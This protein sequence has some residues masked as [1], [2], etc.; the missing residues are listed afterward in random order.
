M[1][2]A[3]GTISI[4]RF[5]V[6]GLVPKGEEVID[7]L[8]KKPFRPFQDGVEEERSGV[9][10]AL[11]HLKGGPSKD[12]AYTFMDG[13]VLFGLRIDTRKV[14][15]AELNAHLE[16]RLER[17]AKE[18]DL[19]F[20]GKEARTSLRD[21]VKAELLGKV[22]PITKVTESIWN[23]RGGSL[24]IAGGNKPITMGRALLTELFGAETR[25][26]TPV[27]LASML[28]PTSTEASLLHG[29]A[30]ELLEPLMGQLFLTW[31]WKRAQEDGGT[32]NE[33]DAATLLFGDSLK[34]V[35]DNGTIKEASLKKGEPT[36]SHAALEA[37][38]EGMLPAAAKV[39][40]LSGELEW[41]FTLDHNLRISGLKLP[42]TAGN[43]Q[44]SRLADRI[45]LVEELLGHIDLRF[46]EFLG[47]WEA[48]PDRLQEEAKAW[49]RQHVNAE[50]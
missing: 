21:E 47:T 48:G 11:N 34:L 24:L 14:P 30:R 41:T 4:T 28:L 44:V 1:G 35:T 26:L 18:K 31:L 43:D 16:L 19:A 40:V 22:R 10:D 7:D 15:A 42:K 39:R 5:Q 45:F 20:I 27:N 37:L 33:G 50:V 6:L 36:E 32:A 23:L 29:Q 12:A 3:K 8:L 49:G 2:I 9:C 13:K 46:K 25:G 17:L 38:A